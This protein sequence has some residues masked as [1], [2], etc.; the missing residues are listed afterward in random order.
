ML[1]TLIA[2]GLCLLIIACA[3]IASLEIAGAISRSRIASIQVALGATTSN[4]IRTSVIEGAAVV[5]AAMAV[6]WFSCW[7]LQDFVAAWLPA[8]RKLGRIQ[9]ER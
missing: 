6:A 9:T 1:W 2:A 3:N 4:L 5:S 8:L 7:M